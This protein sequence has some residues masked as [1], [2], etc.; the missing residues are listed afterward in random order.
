MVWVCEWVTW[1][2]VFAEFALGDAVDVDGGEGHFFD[3]L[4]AV[5][6]LLQALGVDVLHGAAALA[7]RYQLVLDLVLLT[8]TNPATLHHFRRIRLVINFVHSIKLSIAMRC[9]LREDLAAA[10][11]LGGLQRYELVL[12]L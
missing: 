11:E 6:P 8:K 9:L 12:K 4:L 5:E 2:I 7:G 3:G 10:L 1:E